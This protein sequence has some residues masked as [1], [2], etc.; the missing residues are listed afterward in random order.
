MEQPKRIVV[1]DSSAL[2][3]YL[4]NFTDPHQPSMNALEQLMKLTADGERAI[5]KILIPDHIFY[6]L[7]GIL[8]ISL[9]IMKEKFAAAD[10]DPKVLESI[11]EMYTQAS[12]RGV[13]MTS[14]EKSIIDPAIKTHV[15]ALL[16]FVARHPDSLV[17]T[18]V[19]KKYCARLK[20]DYSMLCAH[21]ES[22]LKNYRPTFADAFHHLGGDFHASDLRVHIGQLMMM[23]LIT[24]RE[25]NDRMGEEE[26][27]GNH[28][29]FLH[30]KEMLD[31]L[32]GKS[33]SKGKNGAEFTK[34]RHI[35]DDRAY[36]SLQESEKKLIQEKPKAEQADAQ[37]LTLRLFEEYPLLKAH[38]DHLQHK[39]TL[40]KKALK[41]KRQSS[42]VVREALGPSQLL[43]EHYCYGGIIPQ[44]KPALLAVA[45]AL[46][47]ETGDLDLDD[48]QH[49]IRKKLHD[50][51]FFEIS[52]TLAQL[53]TIQAIL[54]QA[55]IDAPALTR[56][57]Q[58]VARQPH[59]LRN[60]FNEACRP[61]GNTEKNLPYEKVFT[62]ALINHTM[63]W[64]DFVRLL[65][66]SN[67]LH[68]NQ[69]ILESARGDVL[70]DQEAG[71]LYLDPQGIEGRLSKYPLGYMAAPVEQR[72][73]NGAVRS[74]YKITGDNLLKYAW[75]ELVEPAKF[76][77]RVS[78]IF[79]ALLAPAVKHDAGA[80]R[81]AARGILG[82]DTLLQIEKD[83]A[84]R[85]ARKH[86]ANAPPYRSVIAALHTT[87]RIT[88]KNL[89]EV[90]TLEVAQNISEQ[91][92]QS[93]V[94]LINHD[95][96]LFP[97]ATTG[98]PQLEASIARQHAGLDPR[99]AQ[100][101]I[102]SRGNKRLHFVNS[103][104]FLD[105]ISTLLGHDPKRSAQWIHHSSIDDGKK[106][107]YQVMDKLIV[108]RESMSWRSLVQADV[109]ARPKHDRNQR[110]SI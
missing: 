72:M 95:S 7:T 35:L 18:E 31:C 90:A 20:A 54:T 24:E 57:V 104:Q 86:L 33:L 45:K 71:T 44:N 4:Q 14:A 85:Y 56:F 32:H 94:W 41:T 62:H 69:G 29:R 103:V 81:E 98:K 36:V 2:L 68:D 5:D 30:T 50:R 110:M 25:Y 66:Q 15:R 28:K 10:R 61:S 96:D 109:E 53:Q 58:G 51:G 49:D 89:G 82:E 19:A 80:V 38:L 39:T 37:Y 84:N 101:N 59:V 60:Q 52:P 75:Q 87:S 79:E 40:T 73:A 88:R 26:T 1:M 105:T 21:S 9:K 23:G 83:F 107:P 77:K 99:L 48:S 100:L 42:D 8:P 63:A 47:I 65:V 43:I 67:S 92:P 16:N 91:N 12:P 108:R 76:P 78:I 27:R 11:V 106:I 13:K 22:E 97:D 70:V 3:A 102:R 17:D 55:H 34:K 93:H 6:E 64:E 46:D 74:Y